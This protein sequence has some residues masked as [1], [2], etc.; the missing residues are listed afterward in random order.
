MPAVQSSILNLTIRNHRYR[1]QTAIPGSPDNIFNTF[2]VQ[3]R[4][5]IKESLRTM[6]SV[7]LLT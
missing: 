4:K 1:E 5:A 3:N 7:P 2:D 6:R